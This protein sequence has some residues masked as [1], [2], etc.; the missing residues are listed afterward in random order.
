MKNYWLALAVTVGMT[1][2]ASSLHAMAANYTD[3]QSN[4]AQSDINSVVEQ[5]VMSGFNDGL[6]H[7]EAW[8]TRAEFTAMTARALGLPPNQANQI[9]ALKKVSRNSWNFSTVDN[10]AW[11]SAYPSGVYRPEN[12]LRRVEMLVGLS[13]ALKK[14]LLTSE[15]ADQVLSQYTDADQVPTN[16]RQ[17][18]ATAIKYNLFASDPQQGSN[19]IAPLRPA[20]RAEVATVLHTLSENRDITVVQNGQVVAKSNS[21]SADQTETTAASSTTTNTESA[22]SSTSNSNMQDPTAAAASTSS[23]ESSSS[24]TLANSSAYQGQTPG[25]SSAA[26]D[27][28]SSNNS[29]SQSSN[30]PVASENGTR[31]FSPYSSADQKINGSSGPFRNSADTIV[32]SRMVNQTAAPNNVDSTATASLPTNA[33]FV[34]TVA[35]ALYSEFNKPGDPVLLI[36]DHDLADASNKPVLPAGSKLLGFVTSV[37]SRNQGGDAQLGIHLSEAITPAGQ[38]IPLSATI[39]NAD[40]LLKAGNMEGVVSKPDH[41]VAALRREINTAEGALYGTKTGKAAVLEEPYATQVSDKP[42][43]P[44][45]KRNDDIVIGVG[46]QLQIR[47][48]DASNSGN[49]TTP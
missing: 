24:S 39:A 18:V 16:V 29:S 6:F 23:T 34:T 28:T 8:V 2:S 32:E 10:S 22:S 40:G 35:K 49:S 45:D 27:E 43:D 7:P 33:T 47:L 25:T 44:M 37:V 11:L 1:V 3:V 48:G 5:N 20:N 30:Q 26:S 31:S 14:P 36:M 38:R 4:W 12:P 17:Q 21:D 42:L 46:D 15:E 13:G 19:Q 41:S 9:Q